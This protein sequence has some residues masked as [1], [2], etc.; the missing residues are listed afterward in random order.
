MRRWL[1]V[2]LLFWTACN[3]PPPPPKAEADPTAAPGYRAA[4]AELAG[5]NQ[6]AAERLK[7]G[8]R[9]EAGAL[10][11]R[12]ESFSRQL[13]AVPRPSLAAL[14]A[15]SDRDQ[16]YGEMLMANKH[17]THARQMLLKNVHRWRN[18]KPETPDTMRR[19]EAAERAV[20]E[21]DRH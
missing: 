3:A 9:A 13:L 19:R 5:L 15:V 2:A 16:M 18:W 11:E 1:A 14:E 21:C 12:G 4:I 17:W 10:I 6:S 7:K 20:A 8:D